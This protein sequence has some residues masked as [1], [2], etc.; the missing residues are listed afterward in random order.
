MS[1]SVTLGTP[2]DKDLSRV[3][4]AAR[5]RVGRGEA[6]LTS[7]LVGAG[8]LTR[9]GAERPGDLYVDLR[10]EVDAVRLELRQE[11]RLAMAELRRAP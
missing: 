6:T 1:C 9:D 5:I 4:L 10:D 11:R 3:E 7:L 2:P 8:G